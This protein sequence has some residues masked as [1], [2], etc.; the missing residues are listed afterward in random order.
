MSS[1]VFW[2]TNHQQWRYDA[3]ILIPKIWLAKW[4]L[5]KKYEAFGCF[6]VKMNLGIEQMAT[7]RLAQ[8][9]LKVMCDAIGLA[10]GRTQ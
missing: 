9:G 8:N 4:K 3:Q 1:R 10:S 2:A 6:W 7:S 5:K